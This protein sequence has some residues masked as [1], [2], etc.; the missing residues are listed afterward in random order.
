MCREAAASPIRLKRGGSAQYRR[1]SVPF[2]R[3]VRCRRMSPCGPLSPSAA[4]AG[5]G[6]LSEDKLTFAATEHRGLNLTGCLV[7]AQPRPKA[8][9]LRRFPLSPRSERS[10]NSSLSICGSRQREVGTDVPL[11]QKSILR[12]RPATLR[13]FQAFRAGRPIGFK[14]RLGLAI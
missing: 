1:G 4:S 5:H 14:G 12:T 11:P 9:V 2:V 6:K 13:L 10:Q 8:H 3:T 7:F